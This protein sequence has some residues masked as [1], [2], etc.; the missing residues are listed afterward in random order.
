MTLVQ[1][2]PATIET[3][4]R[5]TAERASALVFDNLIELREEA[6]AERAQ[7]PPVQSA[8]HPGGETSRTPERRLVDAQTVAR[9]LD[10]DV[11]SIYRHSAELGA[12][13]VGRR[14]RFDLD[15]ALRNWPSDESD[16]CPS[17]RSQPLQIP[18]PKQT[19]GTDQWSPGTAHCHLL[20]VGRR[21]GAV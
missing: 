18:A 5:R 19:S 12:L 3:I 8:G 13:R 16:R 11:K 9:A 4:V 6:R 21:T 15:R 2:D 10:V 14:L 17:E 1:L 20:P 7:S